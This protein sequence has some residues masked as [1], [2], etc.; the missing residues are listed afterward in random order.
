MHRGSAKIIIPPAYKDQ[1]SLEIVKR[2]SSAYS[3]LPGL[4]QY[5]IYMYFLV[6]VISA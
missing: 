2:L 3:E 4:H 5:R 1:R 6:V